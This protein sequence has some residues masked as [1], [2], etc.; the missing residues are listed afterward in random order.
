[1]GAGPQPLGPAGSSL[2]DIL[3]VARNIVQAI[4][5]AAQNY[6]NV[7]GA[8]NMSGITAT[9][10]VKASAGRV[11]VISVIVA[12]SAVGAIYDS[13]VATSLVNQI[14]V[15]PMAIGV[16]VVNLPVG[17]GIVV[18]PGTGHTLTISYS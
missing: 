15:I 12:G 8:L 16:Y 2:S 11:C 5:S 1:M 13:N 7:Q 17:L 14:Y 3:T 6:L 10:L 18:V 9:K 4:N